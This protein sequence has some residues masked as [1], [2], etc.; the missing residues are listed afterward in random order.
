M[1]E[2]SIDKHCYLCNKMFICD[3]KDKKKCLQRKIE[4][5]LK[6][7]KLQEMME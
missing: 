7:K 6:L 5:E 3:E 4:Q 1:S 2:G